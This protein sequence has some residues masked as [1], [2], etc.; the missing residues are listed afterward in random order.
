MGRP[1]TG[2]G[3]ALPGRVMALW[4]TLADETVAGLPRDAAAGLP[5]L[6]A[7]MTADVDERNR[8]DRAGNRNRAEPNTLQA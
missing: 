6:L 4:C 2:S 5:A 7:A 1:E 3:R 8:A